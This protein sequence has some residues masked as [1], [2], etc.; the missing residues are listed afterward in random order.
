[1]SGFYNDLQQQ[2][3]SNY[4]IILWTLSRYPLLN[5]QNADDNRIIQIFI[6]FFQATLYFLDKIKGMS[7]YFKMFWREV[8]HS[9]DKTYKLIILY[10]CLVLVHG[11]DEI[12]CFIKV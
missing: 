12:E 6:I 11:I 10:E 4:S 5:H 7:I 2:H 9:F 8:R 3:S 1:M